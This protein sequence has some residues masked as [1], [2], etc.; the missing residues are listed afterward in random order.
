MVEK[1][2]RPGSKLAGKEYEVPRTGNEARD[3]LTA[4][5]TSWRTTH[6]M[7]WKIHRKLWTSVPINVP[8]DDNTSKLVTLRFTMLVVTYVFFLIQGLLFLSWSKLLTVMIPPWFLFLKHGLRYRVGVF[9][10]SLQRKYT[11]YRHNREDV[12]GDRAVILPRNS[13]PAVSVLSCSKF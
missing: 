8:S 3:I 1:T 6:M 2:Q 4:T 5:A 9:Q 7:Q 12:T 11:V 10:P 13:V